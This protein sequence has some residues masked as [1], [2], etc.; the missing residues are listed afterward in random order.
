MFQFDALL[1]LFT[2]RNGVAAEAPW[3]YEGVAPY[4]ATIGQSIQLLITLLVAIS[5]D[6][7]TLHAMDDTGASDSLTRFT[8]D[9][10]LQ[11]AECVA[12]AVSVALAGLPMACE[13]DRASGRFS[14]WAVTPD[15]RVVH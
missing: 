6:R 11:L 3:P 4:N 1:H 14:L 8:A 9:E 12:E 15:D 13:F 7:F 10:A 5:G 2:A